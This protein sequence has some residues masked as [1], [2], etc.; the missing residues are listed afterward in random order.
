M[1]VCMALFASAALFASDPKI[2]DSRDEVVRIM[3]Q[4]GNIVPLAAGGHIYSY[5]RGDV[6]FDQK[7]VTKLDLITDEQL[8]KRDEQRRQA[9]A[10]DMTAPT[11]KSKSQVLADFCK[12]YEYLPLRVPKENARVMVI[13]GRVSLKYTSQ[14]AVIS[15]KIIDTS[16]GGGGSSYYAWVRLIDSDKQTVAQIRSVYLP[17]GGG[18]CELPLST[19][20]TADRKLIGTE[21]A[22]QLAALEEGVDIRIEDN[23]GSYDPLIITSTSTRRAVGGE[24]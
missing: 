13:L 5:P 14:G 11:P 7:S 20:Y 16:R 24:R 8:K 1:T 19:F 21:P 18:A 9:P 3:G 10:K 12:A 6:I 4:P 2:G 17:V 22:R 15:M 23:A